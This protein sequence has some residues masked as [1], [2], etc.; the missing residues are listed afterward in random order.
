MG[1]ALKEPGPGITEMY[2]QI[3]MSNLLHSQGDEIHCIVQKPINFLTQLLTLQ[4]IIS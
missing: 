1:L 3:F 4:V 2:W